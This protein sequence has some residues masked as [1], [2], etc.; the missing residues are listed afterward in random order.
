[1]HTRHVRGAERTVALVGPHRR[2]D[3]ALVEK[4]PRDAGH[5]RRKT[6]VGVKH[7]VARLAPADGAIIDFRQR[8][9]AVPVIEFFEA[10]PFGL[11]L[12]VAVRQARIGV[13]HGRH[14]RIHHRAFNPV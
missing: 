8:R 14:Q 2:V 4:P 7:R 11:E 9:I 13:L 12:V 3:P 10:E 1:M 6:I 5:L